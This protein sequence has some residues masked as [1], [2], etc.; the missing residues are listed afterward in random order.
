MGESVLGFTFSQEW[1]GEDDPYFIYLGSVEVAGYHAYLRSEEGNVGEALRQGK[2]RPYVYSIALNVNPYEVT[3]LM[4]S[5]E[6]DTV[7]S[8]ATCKLQCDGVLIPEKLTPLALDI[9]GIL[10]Y[11]RESFNS[12]E[13]N[14]FFLSHE[15]RK[16]KA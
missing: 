6:V 3:V 13:S 7:L 5:A 11:I 15:E 12:S 8:F 16:D 10:E 1:I 2:L 14:Q 4:L 9:L